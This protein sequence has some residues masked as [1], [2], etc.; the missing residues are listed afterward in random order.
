MEEIE[1]HVDPAGIEEQFAPLI[2]GAISHF[3]LQI[4]LRGTV[5]TYPGSQHT[6]CIN[7]SLL[8]LTKPIHIVHTSNA[9]VCIFYFAW[10]H[11][12]A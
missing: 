4:R 6:K 3:N 9:H 8:H 10:A 11:T 5:H 7:S 12:C 1:I 2:E